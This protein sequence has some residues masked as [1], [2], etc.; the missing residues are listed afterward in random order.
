MF[1]VAVGGAIIGD[2]TGILDRES[3]RQPL[4]AH[5][6]IGASMFARCSW[7]LA[8]FGEVAAKAWRWRV[9]RLKTQSDTSRRRTM[10]SAFRPAISL[11][12]DDVPGADR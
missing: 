4:G 11:K 5:V 9:A 12:V 1:A 7:G 3:I 6:S 2:N 8:G 10:K